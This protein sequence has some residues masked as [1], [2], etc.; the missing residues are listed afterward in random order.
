MRIREENC[1]MVLLAVVSCISV[2]VAAAA[3]LL[4]FG[5]TKPVRLADRAAIHA[6]P[7]P[8]ADK[9]IIY[10]TDQP[11]V[12]VIGAPFVPNTNPRER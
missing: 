12:R 5:D 4:G 1:N 7:A 9:G 2:T 10:V 6:E 8:P 11:P 3:S